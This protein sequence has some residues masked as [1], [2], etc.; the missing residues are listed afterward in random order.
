MRHILQHSRI[1]SRAISCMPLVLFFL[2][3][4]VFSGCIR[5]YVF[6]CM[7]LSCCEY[8][9]I[10]HN[11]NNYY[12][13][14]GVTAHSFVCDAPVRAT[15]RNTKGHSGFHGCEKCHD[16]GEWHNKVTFLSTASVLRTD[17]ECAHMYDS[18]HHVGPSVLSSLPV[19]L[20]SQFQTYC[21]TVITM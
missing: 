19:G 8:G 11:N 15:L 14:Y 6:N 7:V 1:T 10:K 12:Y 18:D 2:L 4:S 21:L 17:E 9:I 3:C 20:V 5:V 16:E 13:Y